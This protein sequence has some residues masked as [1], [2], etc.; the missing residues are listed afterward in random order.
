MGRL[1]WKFFLFFFFAQLTTVLVVSL[2]IGM[3]NDKRDR[4]RR[5]IDAA[6]PARTM[7]LAAASTLKINGIESL[8]SLLDIWKTEPI[9]QLYVV[10][11]TGVELLNRQLPK[12]VNTSS[13]AALSSDVN[14]RAIQQVQADDGHAYWLFVEPRNKR[15]PP[16]YFNGIRIQQNFRYLFPAMPL[17]VGIFVSLL[18]AAMLAWYFSKPIKQLRFA[19]ESAASGDLDARVGKV[20]Q[21]RRDELADLGTAFDVMVSRVGQLIQSQ[22]HLMHQV[23]HELRSP[24]ARLQIAIGLIKQQSAQADATHPISEKIATSLNRI[25]T[26]SVRMDHLVGE[27]LTLSRL[28]SGMT[29]FKKEPVDLNELLQELVDDANFEGASNHVN[30]QYTAHPNIQMQA[31]PEL[32]QRAIDNVLR[33]AVKYSPAKT[34]VEVSATIDHKAKYIIIRVADNGVGVKTSEL[35]AIFKPFYRSNTDA[36]TS[37]NGYGLGLAITKQIIEAHC[38]EISA[39]SM[40]NAGLVITIKLPAI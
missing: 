35:E 1:Y 18:F 39:S 6:P 31:Q 9:P 25:E 33:N 38:G 8:K 16:T 2:A 32:L 22:T 37:V 7:V 19:F 10:N 20:M 23:S 34:V 13:L 15:P 14:N 21:G 28:E 4:E 5:L 26:E 27:L 30:V 3:V 24:L 36:A 40:E 12:G 17:I 29:D 11:E